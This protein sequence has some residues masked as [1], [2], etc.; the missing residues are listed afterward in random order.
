MRT[1]AA[2]SREAHPRP[3]WPILLLQGLAGLALLALAAHAAYGLGGK[4]A[5]GFFADWVYNGIIVAA[6][7]LCLLRA[8]L[9]PSQQRAWLVLGVGIACWAAGEIYYT[10][11]LTHD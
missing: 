7:A 5:D 11:V 10:V 8:A 6:A 9:T 1:A 3:P 2:S 4:G